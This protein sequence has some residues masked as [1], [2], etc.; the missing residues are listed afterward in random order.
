MTVVHPKG[1]GGLTF[2]LKINCDR[3]VEG[4]K[5]LRA[6]QTIAANHYVV[7]T[8]SKHGCPTNKIK[9]NRSKPAGPHYA[10]NCGRYTIGG[11]FFDFG[12]LFKF[13]GDYVAKLDSENV[14]NFNMCYTTNKYCKNSFGYANLWNAKVMDQCENLAS[15][16]ANKQNGFVTYAL[17]NPDKKRP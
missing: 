1:D 11:M 3:S 2:E 8:A 15:G 17:T 12:S 4:L 9:Y 13:G 10:F 5:V 7:E 6:G 16:V 14:I